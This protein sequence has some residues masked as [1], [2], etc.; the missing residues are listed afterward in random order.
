MNNNN[1]II[2]LDMKN[3]DLFKDNKIIKKQVSIPIIY[4]CEIFPDYLTFQIFN[5]LD[6]KSLLWK[7]CLIN[8]ELKSVCDSYI[9]KIK[10][11]DDTPNEVFHRILSRFS[12]TRNINQYNLFFLFLL[13]YI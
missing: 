5:F 13:Y 4:L 2:S 11:K 8:K 6:T 9:D 12:Y 1:E 10:L 3:L 7:V